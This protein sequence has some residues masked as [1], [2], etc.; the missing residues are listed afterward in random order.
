MDIICPATGAKLWITKEKTIEQRS[1]YK[2]TKSG[3]DAVRSLAQKAGVPTQGL[4]TCGRSK[5]H[6][7]D[8]KTIGYLT[9]KG[10]RIWNVPNLETFL[11]TVTEK[12]LE[13]EVQR[14]AQLEDQWG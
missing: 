2:C 6:Y 13:D 3:E 14:L 1:A 7:W 8:Q 10:E 5:I 12:Q 11:P 4:Q 9:K